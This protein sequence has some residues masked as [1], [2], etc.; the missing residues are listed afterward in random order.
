MNEMGTKFDTSVMLHSVQHKPQRFAS[1]SY[2]VNQKFQIREKNIIP[3]DIYLP[4]KNAIFLQPFFIYLWF[5]AIDF[6]DVL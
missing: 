6:G 2:A 4:I 3:R 1:N 5:S